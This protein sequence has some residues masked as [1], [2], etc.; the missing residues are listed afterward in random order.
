MQVAIVDQGREEFR[1]EIEVHSQHFACDQCGRSFEPLSPH[2]FSFN[3]SLGWC[4]SCEGIGTETGA[5]LAALLRDGKLTLEQGAVALWPSVEHRVSRWMLAALSQQMDV[6]IDVPFESLT[7]KARRALLHGTGDHWFEV[8]PPSQGA[9]KTRPFFRFQYK[10]LYP[11]LDEAS[12]LS[13]RFRSRMEHLLSEVECGQ[14]GGSRLREDASAV[15]FRGKTIHDYCRLPLETFR[16]QI[17]Q[18]KLQ[19]REKKI[20]GELI[21]EIENRVT[22]LCNVGLEYLSLARPAPSLSGGESQRIRLASQVGSGL[23]GILYVL[24]EPTIGLHPRDNS[25]LL[26][27]LA[28]LRD[29]GNTLLVVEHDREVIASADYLLDFGPRAGRHGGQIVARGR[30]E[31][32]MRKRSSVTGPYLSGKKAIP[33]PKNRRVVTG[34]SSDRKTK[35]RGGRATSSQKKPSHPAGPQLQIIGARHNNLQNIDVEIPLGTFTVVTGVSGSGKS[36]LVNDILYN[37]LARRLHRAQTV[38]APH[39]AIRGIENIN[40]VICVDQRPLGNS[41][42]SNPATYTGLFELIRSLYAQLPEARVRGYTAR[43]FSF[44]APGGRCDECDGNGQLAVEMHFLPDVWVQ[45]DTCHGKRYNPETLS[46]RYHGRSIADV[47][48]MP[49]EEALKLFDKIP[50]IRRILKTLCDVGLGYLPLGQSAPTL[51]GGEAQRVKLAAELAR[52]DTG[53][54]L[55]LLDE[56]TTGLHFEDLRKLLDVLNRLVDLGNSVVVIEHNLDVIKTADWIIDM[57]PDAGDE[58]GRIVTFGTPEQVA[59]YASH[60]AKAKKKQSPRSYTGEILAPVLANGPYE[61]RKVHDFAAERD[62]RAGDLDI[63][64]IGRNQK[65]PWEI[66]GRLWHKENRVAHNGERCRWDGEILEKII[67]KIEQAGG[68][69]ETDWNNRSVVEVAAAKKSHGWFFHALTGEE[70]LLKIKFRTVSKTF[71][72]E[73][74]IAEV[75]MTPLNDMHDLPVYGTDRR[76]KCRNLR[77]PWQEI[78]LRVHALDEI[79]HPGFWKMLDQAISGFK[80]ITEKKQFHPED[81]MPWKVLGQKW[82]FARKGFPLGRSPAWPAEILEEIHQLLEEVAPQGQFL[83][84]N[85][86]VVHVFVPA[87]KESWATLYTKKP[88]ALEL[89]LSGPSGQFTLGRIAQLGSERELVSGNLDTLKLRFAT[90]E[91]L[92]HTDPEHGDLVTFFREHLACLENAAVV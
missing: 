40:K 1:W 79:D 84:N 15:Q 18:W 54:T 27:A 50:K 22:F 6:P 56:P 68:F 43:R 60:A 42:T 37:S 51:S 2:N 32:I 73:S 44:N 12:R 62:T 49:C 59:A 7:G 36:S 5:N 82:H 29:L 70:W 41:P 31:E 17:G 52:P 21:R 14:C 89:W 81:V 26:A 16:R 10:G 30:P 88:A 80:K 33:I 53:Q 4:E 92:Q 76:V 61:L 39:D 83:W 46:V 45:C 3:S 65:M 86:Q 90:R 64:Q 67:D 85:Q 19:A 38:P 47:L 48:E 66:N 71:K 78:E 34:Q 24:D 58:G 13:A 20:A 91:S 63:T 8:R 9:K 25:R 57:G 23:C 77:G 72:R 75:G 35:T 69:R 55:Y 11:A 87:Q 28:Q 74:L